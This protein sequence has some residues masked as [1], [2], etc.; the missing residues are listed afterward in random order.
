VRKNFWMKAAAVV[1]A[2]AMWL[3]VMSKGQT[4]V[5]LVAPLV[6]EN[7]PEG[8]RVTESGSQK[9]VLSIKGRNRFV[10]KL[11]PEKVRVSLDLS[12]ITKGRNKLTI[13]RDDVDLPL[14]LSVVS[15]VPTSVNIIA[16]EN[17]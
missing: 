8:L 3:F 15:I 12:D 11:N 6:L 14:S 7:V 1:L 2:L 4:E 9:V 16:E 5:S 17:P 13:D 10:E